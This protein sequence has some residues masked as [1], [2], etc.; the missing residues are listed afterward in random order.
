MSDTK[1]FLGTGW[2]FPVQ[3]SKTAQTVLMASDEDDIRQSL[4]ILLSTRVGERLMQPKYGCNVEVLVFETIDETLITYVKDLVFTAI[5]YFEPRI[6]PDNVTVQST[7]IEGIIEVTIDYT[8]RSTNSRHN[9]VFPFYLDEGNLIVKN[10]L[11][12]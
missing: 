1:S 4:Q 11:N 9:M 2:A 7:D 8:I 3:F 6:S 10:H 5:Y 12:R